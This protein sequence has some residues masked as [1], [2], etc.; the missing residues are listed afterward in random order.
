VRGHRRLLPVLLALG[1][2]GSLI[3]AAPPPKPAPPPAV[4]VKVVSAGG[5]R[6]VEA[7]FPGRLIAT[8]FP[9]GRDGKRRV[10]ALV[11]SAPDGPRE[12]YLVETAGAGG[13]RRLLGD[14]PDK[15]SVLTAA[16]IGEKSGEKSG[17]SADELLLGAPGVLWSL[18]TV[19][20]P[21]APRQILAAA[22][23][24]PHPVVGPASL[25]VAEVGHLWTWK[26][27][28]AGRLIAGDS[29]DLPVRATRER[30][31]LRLD[32]PEVGVLSQGNGAPPLYL[33]GPEENGKTRLRTLLLTR[34][35]EGKPLRT[36]AWSRFAHPETVNGHWL[37]QIDGKPALIVTT[38]DAEK[39]SLFEERSLRV[40]SLSTDR[41]RSGQPP[42][43]AVPTVARR[44]FPVR[45]FVLDLDRDGHDDL[46]V[47]QQE[48]LRG[49]S[50]VVE[51][52][53]GRGDGRFVPPSRKVS[54][55]IQARAWDYGADVTGDGRPDLVA[56]QQKKLLVFAGTADP[57]RDLLDRRPRLTLDLPASEPVSVAVSAGGGEGAAVE[58]LSGNPLQPLQM[59][60][61]DGDGR[62]EIVY[63]VKDDGGRGRVT[64]IQI[65]G[66]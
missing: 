55:D 39:V 32:T 26:R 31:A 65:G 59:I 56:L 2:T 1:L 27:D 54:L 15:A 66:K 50:L 16:G 48:G 53:F 40:F 7:V 8:A 61:L 37:V 44:W 13:L 11:A 36:E 9:R 49:K 22:G 62:A 45:P 34:D 21:A 6:R 29:F 63:T 24:D 38:N 51:A 30:G 64:V 23:L 12:L 4:G 5:A 47:V 25:A 60:D 10:V 19:E 52:W 35:A 41:S 28:R 3:A 20:A 42:S 18:G 46:A 17:D 33:V 43:L 14:L 57:R 58:P